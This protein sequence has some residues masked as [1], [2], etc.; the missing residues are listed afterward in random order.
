[1]RMTFWSVSAAEVS[2]SSVA[3][4]KSGSWWRGTTHSSNGEREA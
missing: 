1:M 2:C 4:P 3:V